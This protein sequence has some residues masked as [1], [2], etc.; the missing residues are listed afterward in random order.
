MSDHVIDNI[1]FCSLPTALSVVAQQT[2]ARWPQKRIGWTILRLFPG[3]TADVQRRACEDAFTAWAAVCGVEP[4]FEATAANALILIG[5]RGIDGPGGV[6]AESQLPNGTLRPVQQW[7]D[8]E[9]WVVAADPP[10]G[11]IDLLRVLMHEIGHALGIGHIESGNLLQPTYSLRIRAPQA[12]D[13]REAQARYG[14]PA[15]TPPP[16]PGSASDVLTIQ[17]RGKDLDI[18]I[19]GYEVTKR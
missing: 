1:P 18:Q 8:S 14:P 2:Q 15:K 4:Y 7:Y 5:T 19:P 9:R 12:G 6:L 10:P 16:P 13:V 17:V 11:T 3:V